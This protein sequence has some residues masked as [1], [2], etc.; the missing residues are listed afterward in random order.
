MPSL[1]AATLW[2]TIHFA[3]FL[4]QRGTGLLRSERRIFVFHV[5]SFASLTFVAAATWF[6]F[7]ATP[8]ASFGATSLHGIYSLTFLEFWSLAEGG[9]TVS[10]VQALADRPVDRDSLLR[11]LVDIGEAKRETRLQALARLGLVRVESDIVRL[12]PAGQLAR[13]LLLALRWLC[14]RGATG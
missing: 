8:L 6:D 3:L 12:T 5:V 14:I 2:C 13:R 1:L 10:L 4:A 9:Y 7:G 11:M